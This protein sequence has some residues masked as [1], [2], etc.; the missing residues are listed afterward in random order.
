MRIVRIVKIVRLS[1]DN[2]INLVYTPIE[3]YLFH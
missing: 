3:G 1:C 2:G